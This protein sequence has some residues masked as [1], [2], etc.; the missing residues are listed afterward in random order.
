MLSI[1]PGSWNLPTSTESWNIAHTLNWRGEPCQKKYTVL[2]GLSIIDTWAKESLG[3]LESISSQPSHQGRHTKPVQRLLLE[4]TSEL[5]AV[6]MR[7]SRII[8][9]MSCGNGKVLSSPKEIYPK[10]STNHS[11]RPKMRT[12]IVSITLIH[13]SIST[14]QILAHIRGLTLRQQGIRYSWNNIAIARTWMDGPKQVHAAV[15]IEC[16]CRVKWAS[17]F[18]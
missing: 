11:C 13:V 2:W 1:R 15:D 3:S 16:K 4:V 12:S 14:R 17:Q 6:H 18:R 7:M 10:V 9:L 5:W 8:Y